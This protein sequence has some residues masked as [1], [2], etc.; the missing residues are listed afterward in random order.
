MK[1]STRVLVALGA[2]ARP[3]ALPS[4]RAA[5][6]RCSRAADWLAPIGTLWVNA[7]R[8]TVIPLVVSLLDHR[9]GV[10]DRPEVDRPARR[11]GR[12]SCSS[13]CSCGHRRRRS[14]RSRRSLF[15]LLPATGG[16]AAAAG[17][18]GRGGQPA[19]VERAGADV[20]ARGSMSLIPTNPIAAA[21]NGAMV[22]LILFTLLLAL[23][24]ARSPADARETLVGVLSRARRRDAGAGALGR[25]LA[26][27]I[28]IFALMLPL[29]RARA[30]RRS[31]API[32]FY[33]V[34]YSVG[35]SRLRCCCSIRWS[36]SSG[37]VPM[38]E[39]RAAPR[40]RRS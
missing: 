34:V 19:G 10:G 27:P 30:A 16:A 40:C 15:A 23:A 4:P 32:G 6:P 24:I 1:E 9:R 5:T 8:M 26:A 3:A 25:A 37:G 17:R 22:P 38:R 31:P 13:C 33:I 35:C 14:C 18:R 36:P 2:G 28:G 29:G 12:C 7:I 20:R 21:A 39:V 11:H